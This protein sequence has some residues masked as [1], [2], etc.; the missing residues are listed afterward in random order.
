MDSRYTTVLE[1]Q[2]PLGEQVEGFRQLQ[3]GGWDEGCAK[4]VFG[5]SVR[6]WKRCCPGRNS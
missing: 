4:G 1:R 6:S 2:N 5:R 3:V